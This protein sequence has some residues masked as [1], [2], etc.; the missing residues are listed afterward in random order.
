MSTA[1]HEIGS[2]G[3]RVAR[4]FLER[5]GII[6]IDGNVRVG[7]GEVDLVG[8]DGRSQLIV[9]VRSRVSECAPVDAF[10]AAKQHQLRRL[11]GELGIGRVDLVAVGFGCRFVSIHWIPFAI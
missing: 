4:W 1:R 3:E 10:D 8:R 6:T 9:E 7:R 2:A 11:S 5:H